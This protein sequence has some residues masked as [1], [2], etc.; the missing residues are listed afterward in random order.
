MD[1]TPIFCTLGIWILGR[2]IHNLII[3]L[4][5]FRP[6]VTRSTWLRKQRAHHVHIHLNPSNN[7]DGTKE[8]R[9]RYKMCVIAYAVHFLFLFLPTDNN[10]ISYALPVCSHAAHAT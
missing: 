7:H 5:S 8:S 2:F 3:I 1:H 10:R 6:L 4:G 9:Y